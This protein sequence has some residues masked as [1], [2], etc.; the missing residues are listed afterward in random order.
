MYA[1]PSKE[2]KIGIIVSKKVDKRATKRNKVKRT[3]RE[4][5]RNNK[6]V[7]GEYI[8]IARNSILAMSQ[9]EILKD[10]LKI[11]KEFKFNDKSSDN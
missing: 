8:I 7:C 11:I 2:L 4:I 10:Y 3:I 1:K 6:P 9:T 5:F